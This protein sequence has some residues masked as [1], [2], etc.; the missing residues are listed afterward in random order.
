MEIEEGRI[1]ECQCVIN[2]RL[3]VLNLVLIDGQPHLVLR[4]DQTAAPALKPIASIPLSREHL[5]P[6]RGHGEIDFL[7]E[8]PITLR[9]APN[10]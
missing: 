9:P 3:D 2:G 10:S 4:W 5:K 1:Y 6:L 8:Q 7:Y